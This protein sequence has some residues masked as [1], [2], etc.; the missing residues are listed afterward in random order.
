MHND[1]LKVILKELG[2][3]PASTICKEDIFTLSRNM[4]NHG[5]SQSGIQ[6]KLSQLKAVLNEAADNNIIKLDLHPFRNF[7][8][9]RPEVR[10]MDVDIDEFQ[11]IRNHKTESKRLSFYLGGINLVD[12]VRVDLS[13]KFKLHKTENKK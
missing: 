8:I 13:G 5:Y 10:L 4:E 9:P 7:K 3:L 1:T 11:K 6:I 12:L 2:N